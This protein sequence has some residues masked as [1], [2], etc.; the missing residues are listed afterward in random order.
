MLLVQKG[1]AG[2][3]HWASLQQLPTTHLPLQQVCPAGQGRVASQVGQQ[4]VPLAQS[5]LLIEPSGIVV[6][7]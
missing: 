1:V 4:V 5:R 7:Q 2:L 6:P 3:A